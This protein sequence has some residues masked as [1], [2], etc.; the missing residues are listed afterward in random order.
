M[1]PSQAGFRKGYST[2]SQALASHDFSQRYTKNYQVFLDL[3][4]A[5]DR[6][7]IPTLLQKLSTRK[8]DFSILSLIKSLFTDCRIKVVVNGL[9]TDPIPTERGLFQGSLLAP[10]LFDLFIDDLAQEIDQF[11]TIGNPSPGLFFADDIKLQHVSQDTMQLMINICYRWSI[12]NGMAFNIGK[13]GNL[14]SFLFSIGDQVIP[15]VDSYKYLGFSHNLSGIDWQSHV[16]SLSQKASSHLTAISDASNLWTPASKLIIF[17]TFIRP[18]LE[19][20]AP[21]LFHWTQHTSPKP[22][23]TELENARSK[24]MSWIANNRQH[25]AVSALLGIPD[26]HHRFLLLSIK[27]FDHLTALSSNNPTVI[28]WKGYQNNQQWL[29]NLLLPRIFELDPITLINPSSN[30]IEPNKQEIINKFSNE[31]LKSLGLLSTYIFTTCRRTSKHSSLGPDSCIFAGESSKLFVSW[32]LNTFGSRLTCPMCKHPFRRNHIQKCLLG[33]QQSHLNDHDLVQL[34]ED[35]K[36]NPELSNTSYNIID[37]LLNHQSY[38]TASKFLQY[39]QSV[40]KKD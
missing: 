24:C 7:P 37:S 13:C 38:P 30:V 21:L 32:R 15:L 26:T 10:F 11:S 2:L 18:Q 1:S 27:F 35:F 23:L 20:G 25:K 4:S 31:H 6:V 12:E 8:A 16:K 5:Y 9:L 3:K 17:K 22:K 14:S 36:Q 39:I 33:D 40:L 34:T 29:K 19:Y 28:L